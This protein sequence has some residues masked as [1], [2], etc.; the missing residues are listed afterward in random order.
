MIFNEKFSDDG[1]LFSGE[2][3]AEK[4]MGAASKRM[5]NFVSVVTSEN[6]DSWVERDRLTKQ[7]ILLFTDKKT[8]PTMFKSFSKKHISRLNL[9]E[10][11]QSEEELCKKYGVTDFPTILALT[12]PEDFESE[13]YEGEMNVDQVSKFL[14]TYAYATPKKPIVTDFTELTVEKYR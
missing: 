14:N 6:Y 9:G 11:K 8:T 3:V 7:K 13:K 4:I 12:N 2:M 10:V 5:Q 1:E